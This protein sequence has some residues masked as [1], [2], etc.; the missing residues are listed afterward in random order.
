MWLVRKTLDHPQVAITDPSN[1]ANKNCD[2]NIICIAKPYTLISVKCY[3]KL[4]LVHNCRLNTFW[5]AHVATQY[6]THVIYNSWSMLVGSA[7]ITFT[8]NEFQFMCKHGWAV[9]ISYSDTDLDQ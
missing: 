1:V 6:E 3:I 2:N 8:I 4:F 7:Y 9:H 5:V